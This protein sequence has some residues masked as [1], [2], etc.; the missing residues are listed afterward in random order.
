MRALSIVVALALAGC[1]DSGSNVK[2]YAVPV[3][4]SPLRG[5]AAAWVTIIEFADFQC[6]YCGQAAAT[7]AQIEAAYPAERGE[8]R[9][10]FKHFPLSFH[11][12][13]MPAAIA[14]E[15]A[16]AQGRF[17]E[18]HDLLFAHQKALSDTDLAGYAAQ[19]GLDL[20]A[21]NACLQSADP[22]ARI[23]ED[24]A[25]AATLGIDGTPTSFVNGRVIMGA[26]PY[27]VFQQAIEEALAAAKQS[28]IAVEEYYDRAVLH[29]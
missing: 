16:G 1:G 14:A 3:G 21:W 10:A 19:L 7:L 9:V 29:R 6:P 11:Q 18:M 17:W 2:T 25:L 12:Y 20:V 23:A 13:A 26:Q 5:P 27:D 8:L 24:Q 28:G 15:C 22:P 4:S